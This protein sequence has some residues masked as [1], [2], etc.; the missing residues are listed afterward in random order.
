[1]NYQFEEIGIGELR[2]SLNITNN[3]EKSNLMFN[4]LTGN[5]EKT[6]QYNIIK[7]YSLVNF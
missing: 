7:S 6:E 2:H 3:F 1:M 5:T 4:H